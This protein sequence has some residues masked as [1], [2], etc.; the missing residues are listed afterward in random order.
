[1]AVIYDEA[2]RGFVREDDA[3][4]AG[5]EQRIAKAQQNR[6]NDGEAN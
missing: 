1:L 4:N 5:N 2:A 6:G 3:G